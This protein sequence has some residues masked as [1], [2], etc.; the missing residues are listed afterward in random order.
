VQWTLHR[1]HPDHAMPKPAS[2]CKVI[3]YPKPDG[4]LAFDRLSSVFI[5]STDREENHPALLTLK[6]P[7]V[8]ANVNWHLCGSGIALLPGRRV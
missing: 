6:N 8:P 4:K 3:A 2:Q 1:Q 7:S 5:S